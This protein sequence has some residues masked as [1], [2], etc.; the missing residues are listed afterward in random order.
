MFLLA[1]V[2]PPSTAPPPVFPDLNPFHTEAVQHVCRALAGWVLT[3]GIIAVIAIVA[4]AWWER[5]RSRSY[6]AVDDYWPRFTWLAVPAGFVA[7]L[8]AMLLA[9]L[10]GGI[11]TDPLARLSRY[12]VVLGALALVVTLVVVAVRSRSGRP[13]TR[14]RS[15]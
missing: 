4:V 15:W 6:L 2:T 7:A 13:G 5:Y 14:Y 8:V 11:D 9:R 1:E 12:C 10:G 3:V